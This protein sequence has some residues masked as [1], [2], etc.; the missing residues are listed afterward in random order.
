MSLVSQDNVI[1]PREHFQEG[2]SVTLTACVRSKQGERA[3]QTVRYQ[4]LHLILRFY[5]DKKQTGAPVLQN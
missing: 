4:C 2:G 5:P 1:K 3:S